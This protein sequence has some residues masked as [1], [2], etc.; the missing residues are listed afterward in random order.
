MTLLYVPSEYFLGLFCVFFVFVFFL[1]SQTAKEPASLWS[2]GG[3]VLL[4]P[5]R[6]I[7]LVL[8]GLSLFCEQPWYTQPSL[9]LW[10]VPVENGRGPL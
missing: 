10:D 4:T 6:N 2:R 9:V 7:F 8:P 5:G 1:S 3:L